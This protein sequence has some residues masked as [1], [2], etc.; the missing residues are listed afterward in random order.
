MEEWQNPQFPADGVPTKGVLKVFENK[1]TC[2][3]FIAQRSN[4]YTFLIHQ[5]LTD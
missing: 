4:S 5:L 2:L 1:K 3:L